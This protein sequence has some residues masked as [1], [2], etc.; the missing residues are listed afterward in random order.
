MNEWPEFAEYL[1]DALS[2]ILRLRKNQP[3]KTN[4]EELYDVL[5]KVMNLWSSTIKPK[6]NY[7]SAENNLSAEDFYVVIYE[8]EE[9]VWEKKM[10]KTRPAS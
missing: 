8:K 3:S 1:E 5:T 9:K 2:D 7:S 6:S 10:R 4:L